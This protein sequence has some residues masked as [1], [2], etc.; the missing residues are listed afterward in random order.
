MIKLITIMMVLFASMAMAQTQSTLPPGSV[1][2]SGNLFIDISGNVWTGKAGSY[3]N[4]GTW[5]K[6]DSLVN[7]GYTNA[8]IDSIA[9]GLQSSLDDKIDVSE[10]GANNG[11]APINSS[12]KIPSQYLDI[13]GLE[14]PTKTSDLTNDGADGTN[15][16]ITSADLPE[17]G[18]SSIL[19]LST[20]TTLNWQSGMATDET[21]TPTGETWAQRFGNGISM[22][23]LYNDGV[24]W[25]DES[26]QI[27]VTYTG[28]NITTVK[29]PNVIGDTKIIIISSGAGGA[30][31]G[32]FVNRGDWVADTYHRGDYVSAP[33]T[34]DPAVKSLYFLIGNSDYVS[35]DEPADDLTHWSELPAVKGDKGDKG[36][37]GDPG[38]TG[39]PGVGVPVGGTAGQILAKVNSTDYNTHWINT[40]SPTKTS[41]LTNDGEDG[42]TP[43]ITA[44]DIAGNYVN[45]T[46]NQSGILGNKSWSGEH[47][48]LTGIINSGNIGSNT[49]FSIRKNNSNR[50]IIRADNSL[51]SGGNLGSNFSINRYSDTGSFLGYSFFIN[52]NNGSVLISNLSGTGTGIVSAT[53]TGLLG[54]MAFGTT[55]GTVSEGNHTHT[56]AEIG[57]KPTTLSGYGITDGAVSGTGGTQVRNNTQLDARY[58][59]YEGGGRYLVC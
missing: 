56:F 8:Q 18:K 25:V 17:G 19:N 2:Y 50:W 57:S 52:R 49:D 28:N 37:Q 51:E 16:F 40:T 21:G 9:S 32:I 44:T 58:R 30:P 15:P 14:I 26:L 33:S 7:L 22:L 20:T 47:T 34:A 27:Q 53:S 46:G 35:E 13:P 1:S 5:L 24:S 6:V 55:A 42:I 41:D 31:T 10:K 39:S 3:T 59:R 43:F 12:G 36:D 45:T 4:L 11:V 38:A 48:F 23:R 54:R 29:F